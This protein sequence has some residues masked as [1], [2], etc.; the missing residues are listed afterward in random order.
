MKGPLVIDL[1]PVAE[2]L[3]YDYGRRFAAPAGAF[4]DATRKGREVSEAEVQIRAMCERCQGVGRIK[5]EPMVGGGVP[6][7]PYDTEMCGK[8]IDGYLGPE[9]VSLSQLKHLL[10]SGEEQSEPSRVPPS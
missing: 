5:A 9:W 6:M 1:S 3:G 2:L 4:G 8:C 10:D 7:P